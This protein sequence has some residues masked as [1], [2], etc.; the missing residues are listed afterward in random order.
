MI[1][2]TAEIICD[3]CKQVVASGDA[4]EVKGFVVNSAVVKAQAHG[5][6]IGISRVTCAWCLEKSKVRGPI[7]V[8]RD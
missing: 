7:S 8:F 4:A 5:A 3:T 6:H 2:L 1:T